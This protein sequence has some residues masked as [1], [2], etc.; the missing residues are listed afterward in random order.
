[1][2][3]II[4]D[5]KKSLGLEWIITKVKKD[6]KLRIILIN[7]KNS[8]FE[9]W[10]IK[11]KIQYINLNYKKKYID[12]IPVLL[13]IILYL[14]KNRTKYVHC[15]LRKASLL[16]LIASYLLRI[17]KRVYTR[18]HGIESDNVRFEKVLDKIVFYLA[19]DI[20]AISEEMKSLTIDN[21]KFIKKK[22]TKIHHGFNLD[23]FKS[24]KLNNFEKIFRKYK[25]KKNYYIIGV[26]SRIVYW[27][28]VD[29]IIDAFIIYK[30]YHNPKSILVLANVKQNNDYSKTVINKL[31]CLNKN[32]YRIIE[33][34]EDILSLYRCFDLFIHVPKPGAYE[35]FGQTYIESMLSKV[36][37]IFSKS[38]I[39]NEICKNRINTYFCNPNNIYSIVDGINFHEKKRINSSLIAK[40]A[41]FRAKYKFNLDDHFSKL[42]QTYNL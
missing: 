31:K 38:G 15:H 41:Y 24:T 16:G 11:N 35:A 1:V 9:K 7:S 13:S 29:K 33:F 40:N 28:N 42:Y 2:I 27:K 39:A 12:F 37:T 20:I 23:Y 19:T 36:P 14:I 32:D 34:E 17:K 18:H 22:V 4:S 30:K 26:I 3:Y 10:I 8:S 25:L 5:V 6:F 21:N